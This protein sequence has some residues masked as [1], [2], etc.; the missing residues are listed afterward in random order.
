MRR[1]MAVLLTPVVVLKGSQ[2]AAPEDVLTQMNNI[3]AKA[4]LKVPVGAV[5]VGAHLP[6]SISFL[7]ALPVWTVMQE[8]TSLAVVLNNLAGVQQLVGTITGTVPVARPVFPEVMVTNVEFWTDNGA[9][10][11][12]SDRFHVFQ[13]ANPALFNTVVV[14]P[15]SRKTSTTPA[16]IH[17]RLRVTIKLRIGP[18]VTCATAGTTCTPTRTVEVR[19]PFVRL[20][21]PTVFAGFENDNFAGGALIVVP[22]NSP[23]GSVSGLLEQLASVTTGLSQLYDAVDLAGGTAAWNPALPN[24]SILLD[25]VNALPGG[26]VFRKANSLEELDEITIVSG[27]CCGRGDA[28]DF[29]NSMIL[30]GVDEKVQLFTDKH[31][32]GDDAWFSVHTPADESHAAV[33]VGNMDKNPSSRPSGRVTEHADN[34]TF[35]DT[36][37]S[38]RFQ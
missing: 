5:P 3:L 34:K 30:V 24:L 10:E 28:D 37:S 9:T 26:A 4:E 14:P 6:I 15:I 23:A 22:S 18:D 17:Y 2:A 29:F 19:I 35:H 1:L 36:I 32:D 38:L 11:L 8:A 21:I 31:F 27:R 12:G 25:A 7:D 13:T 20:A 33:L 16:T